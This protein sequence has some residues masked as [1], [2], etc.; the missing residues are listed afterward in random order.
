MSY[1]KSAARDPTVITFQRLSVGFVQCIFDTSITLTEFMEKT[2]QK[3]NTPRRKV[4]FVERKLVIHERRSCF[5]F[6][7]YRRQ[8]WS[9]FGSEK[10]SNLWYFYLFNQRSA[11]VAEFFS[12]VVFAMISSLIIEC[13]L[14]NL[15]GSLLIFLLNF[16]KEHWSSNSNS[17]AK[18]DLH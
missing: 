3:L 11:S 2:S 4:R 16:Y 1:W 17:T 7:C 18:K 6:F 13:K 9:S 15:V 5:K 14:W 12:F 10:S 8:N